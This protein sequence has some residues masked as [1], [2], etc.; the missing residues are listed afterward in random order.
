MRLLVF[1]LPTRNWNIFF[2]FLCTYNFFK[3]FSLPTRNW[4]TPASISAS[5]FRIKFSAYLR[6]IETAAW[7]PLAIAAAGFQPTYEELKPNLTSTAIFWNSSFSAYLR[8]IETFHLW[9]QQLQWWCVFSLPTRNWNKNDQTGI[10]WGR[11]VFSLP[12]RNWNIA[13]GISNR[14]LAGSFQ[15]TYE[16]LKPL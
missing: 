11:I 8:G 9:W 2:H 3:V 12:T 4:N 13:G 7:P 16:E 14:V 10:W 1:S 5:I 6:G 15:P